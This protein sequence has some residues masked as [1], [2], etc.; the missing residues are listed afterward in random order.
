MPRPP[1]FEDED[2]QEHE[3]EEELGCGRSPALL[4]VLLITLQA[5]T[6]PNR[7]LKPTLEQTVAEAP[8]LLHAVAPPHAEAAGRRCYACLAI[9]SGL[10]C[11][12]C[13]T[14][15]HS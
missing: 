15:M 8:S 6:R 13:D 9:G 1:R 4:G 14:A 5:P 11:R 2:E 12:A 7:E 10:A 3:N